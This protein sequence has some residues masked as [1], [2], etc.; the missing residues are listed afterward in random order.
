M[1]ELAKHIVGNRLAMRRGAEQRAEFHPQ[2]QKPVVKTRLDSWKPEP[3]PRMEPEFEGPEIKIPKKKEALAT[4]TASLRKR[5]LKALKAYALAKNLNFSRWV[6]DT[7]TR[8]MEN[9]PL[10]VSE[11]SRR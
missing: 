9:N 8:D 4:L 10:S 6:R 11:A 1:K 3:E 2:E 7:L 5:E